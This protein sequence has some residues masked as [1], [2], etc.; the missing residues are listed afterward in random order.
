MFNYDVYRPIYG[1]LLS[2]KPPFMRIEIETC[3]KHI[4]I[5]MITAA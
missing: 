1:A 5:Q 3:K 2:H 4:F